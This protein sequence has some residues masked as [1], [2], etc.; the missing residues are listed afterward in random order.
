MLAAATSVPGPAHE[1]FATKQLYLPDTAILITRFLTEGGVGELIDFMP[2]TGG[3][4]SDRA[5]AS[6]GCCDACGGE[7]SFDIEVAPRFDYGRQ[8]H[9]AE[10]Q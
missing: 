9:R 6:F 1:A 5:S 4:P 7:V 10:C 3:S 2:I 8:R